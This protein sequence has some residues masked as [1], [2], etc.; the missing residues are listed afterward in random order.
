MRFVPFAVD[1][2]RGNPTALW[3]MAAGVSS[4]GQAREA[5]SCKLGVRSVSAPYV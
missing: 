3:L 1:K 2:T 4:Q 5:L